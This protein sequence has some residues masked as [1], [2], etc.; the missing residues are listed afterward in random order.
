MNALQKT[1][2]FFLVGG[3]LLGAGV[4]SFLGFRM[5]VQD[6]LAADISAREILASQVTAQQTIN[7]QQQVSLETAEASIIQLTR[8]IEDQQR[9]HESDIREL[10]LYRRIESG[11]LERGVLVDEVQLYNSPDGAMLRVTL[12]QVGA[13]A[14]IQGKLGVALIGTEL[15]GADDNKVVLAGGADET[16]VEFDFRFMSRIAIPIPDTLPH[17]ASAEE[18]FPWLEG[19]DMVEVYITPSDNRRSP[20]RVTIPADRMI[21]GP[22]E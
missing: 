13:R 17:S 11:G 16:A 19:L 6:G 18:P 22:P 20:K 3:V 4:G 8:N 5:G 14:E 1:V 10:E 9:A 2:A 21:L 7:Q 12:L 15:P